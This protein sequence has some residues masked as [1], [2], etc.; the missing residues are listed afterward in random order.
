MS[1]LSLDRDQLDLCQKTAE[2]AVSPA[3][4]YIDYHSSLSIER[5]ILRLLGVQGVLEGK[6][7]VNCLV[8]ALDRSQ[9]SRGAAWWFCRAMAHHGI[10]TPSR[11][12]LALAKKEL[13]YLNVPEV[14]PERIESVGRALVSQALE[15]IHALAKS[16][17]NRKIKGRLPH[18]G[19]L[20]YVIVG[21]GKIEED[22]LQA[23]TAV[24]LGAD[25]IAL[26]QPAHH[27][28][29]DKVSEGDGA[30]DHPSFQNHLRKMRKLLD[31]LSETQ[32]RSIALA[33]Y[34]SGACMPERVVIAAL[35]GVDYVLS[36][37]LTQVLFREMNLK[38]AMTDQH[39]ARHVGAMAGLNFMMGEDNYQLNFDGHREFSQILIS[40]LINVMLA[41]HAGLSEHQ[42]VLGHAMEVDPGVEDSLLLEVAQVELVRELFP[43]AALKLMPPTRY[44]TGDAF[45]SQRYETSYQLIGTL[46][47][48]TIQ[49]MGTLTGSDHPSY[50]MD[51]HLSFQSSNYLYHGAHELFREIAFHSNGKIVRWGRHLLESTLRLLKKIEG[52]GLM[53]SIEQG[54]FANRP[55][56]R[57]AGHGLEGI[58]QKDR[59][60]YNPF[61]APEKKEGPR[62]SRDSESFSRRKNR[63][64]G[65]HN[66]RGGR[67]RSRRSD[68]K[69]S[70][71]EASRPASPPSDS[72]NGSSNS[73]QETSS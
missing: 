7:L 19:P 10:Q 40:H 12:A 64:G 65:G 62:E 63:G 38:R 32:K 58:F 56:P 48:Q 15:Q 16:R 4:R 66:R 73:S 6:P 25:I 13:E 57:D 23:Q 24:E 35:E 2:T 42:M 5:A 21:T 72:S 18:T 30:E 50:G 44:Q 71:S 11:L 46:T 55:R 3:L 60:Y 31:E 39:F 70:K 34:A 36:D 53:S 51:R 49:S 29:L 26:A 61:L 52:V 59:N 20:R 54:A 37:A 8:D 45:A 33:C 27:D 69:P 47:G 41:R 28:F 14:A 67:H 22:F 17:Q 1:K 68:S 43:H 9:L